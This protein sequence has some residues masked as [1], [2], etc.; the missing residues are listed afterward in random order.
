MDLD[1]L[2]LDTNKMTTWVKNL[3]PYFHEIDQISD[4]GWGNG[5]FMAGDVHVLYG[6]V[7]SVKPHNVIEVGCGISTVL[8]H[9][10]LNKNKTEYHH[11]GID[12]SPI[13]PSAEKIKTLCNFQQVKVQDIDIDQ[14]DILKRND[15][16]FIDS[17]H[18]FAPDSDV[19]LILHEI[20][21]RL[22]SGTFIH[23]HDI[24][25]PHTCQEHYGHT[26]WNEQDAVKSMLEHNT[27]YAILWA[28]Y[29]YMENFHFQAYNL[30]PEFQY[31][32]M[33]YPRCRPSSLW[34]FKN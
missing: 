12:P 29:W 4:F 28:G 5:A 32:W 16:L 17:S 20:L 7:R 15:I 6:L 34:L 27:Q 21:P 33:H 10:A 19:A 25:W 8:I 1:A 18:I 23:F 24:V 22:K 31:S 3:T 26:L 30:F 2:N 14:F 11:I 9:T 13:N